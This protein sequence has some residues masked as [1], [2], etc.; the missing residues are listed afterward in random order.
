MDIFI[1]FYYIGIFIFFTFGLYLILK[2]N[3]NPIIII[4]YTTHLL[5]V[6]F[7]LGWYSY[8]AL[9]YYFDGKI[10]NKVKYD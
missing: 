9:Y 7:L 2:Y 10:T 8:I 6:S 5:F 4:I 3:T 1:L